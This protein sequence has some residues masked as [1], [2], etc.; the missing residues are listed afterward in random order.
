MLAAEPQEAVG[1]G[2]AEHVLIFRDF[3]EVMRSLVFNLTEKLSG[4]G[5]NLDQPSRWTSGRTRHAGLIRP[6]R[7]NPKGSVDEFQGIGFTDAR[8]LSQILSFEIEPLH[9]IV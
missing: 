3:D 4:R 7:A 6:L 8:P 5:I 2:S 9:T 1:H